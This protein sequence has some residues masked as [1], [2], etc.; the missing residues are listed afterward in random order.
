VD[1]VLEAGAERAR[2]IAEPVIEE[3]KRLVGFWR[4]GA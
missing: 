2:E 4:P 1:R 3:T